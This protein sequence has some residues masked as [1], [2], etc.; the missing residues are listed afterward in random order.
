MAKDHNGFAGA[1]RVT[2]LPAP[3][4]PPPAAYVPYRA[5]GV[6]P[7]GGASYRAPAVPSA[8]GVTSYRAQQPPGYGGVQW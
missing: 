8:G 4:R 5:P 6:P 1:F 3:A 7:A 2:G